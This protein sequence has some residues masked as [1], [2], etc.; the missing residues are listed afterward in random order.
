[1][2]SSSFL[3]LRVESYQAVMT[4]YQ[5]HLWKKIV[6]FLQDLPDDKQNLPNEI[7]ME[8]QNVAKHT[9]G[10]FFNTSDSSARALASEVILRTHAWVCSFTLAL[11]TRIKV[12]EVPFERDGHLSKKTDM[13]LGKLK[14]TR[15][16]ACSLCLCLISSIKIIL[17]TPSFH[18]Q[19]LLSTIFF[20]LFLVK[21][22]MSATTPAGYIFPEVT[23]EKVFQIEA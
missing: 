14:E 4:C 18:N 9:L 15:M 2:F 11:N 21:S 6:L 12:E 7:L 1:M 3:S 23:Q 22:K 17:S 10:P 19:T 5:F 13:L 20:G 8:G 16:T